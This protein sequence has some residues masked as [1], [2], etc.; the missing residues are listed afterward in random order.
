MQC[1]LDSCQILIKL[2]IFQQIF[3]KKFTKIRP[4]GAELFRA[5]RWTDRHDEANS[6]FSQFCE[7]V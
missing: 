7:H 6:R 2:K 4:D 1:T 3:E 5:G